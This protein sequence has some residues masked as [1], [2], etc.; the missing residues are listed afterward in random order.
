MSRRAFFVAFA[1]AALLLAGVVSYF[2]SSGPDGLE[3]VATDEGIA[4][5]ERD[6]ATAGGPLA[7]YGVRGV[8]NDWLSGGLAGVAGVAVVLV[9]TTGVSFVV[10]RKDAASRGS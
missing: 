6:H 3:R 8:D 2:A 10:R 9:M 1:A 4:K 7:D 5:S